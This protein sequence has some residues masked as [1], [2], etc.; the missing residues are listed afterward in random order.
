V[1]KRQTVSPIVSGEELVHGFTITA[2]PFR[3]TIV[4]LYG[5]ANSLKLWA[6]NV[7]LSGNFC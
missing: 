1:R 7:F 2:K 3:L 5:Y 6:T 4:D